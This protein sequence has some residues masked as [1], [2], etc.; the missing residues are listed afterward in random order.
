MR[1]RVLLLN[2]N[3]VWQEIVIRTIRSLDGNIEICTVC[4]GSDGYKAAIEN[5]IDVFIV[6]AVLC[7]RRDNLSG[8]SFISRIR[9]CDKY[10]FAP[11][12]VIC[13]SKSQV[14]DIFREHHCYD[15][16]EKPYNIE[17]LKRV[18]AGA[19]KYKT[20]EAQR[21]FVYIKQ[22]S[23]QVALK[24]KNIVHIQMKDRILRVYT[25]SGGMY[26]VYYKSCAELLEDV[27]CTFLFQCSRSSI[28][29]LEH[30]VDVDFGSR[31]IM[32]STGERVRIG[33]TY[34]ELLK[35]KLNSV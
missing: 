1:K 7:N 19:L 26:D 11:V 16:I 25:I 22:N 31:Y 24:C 29:N 27:G 10:L 17:Y 6:N 18:V 21:K 2:D 33:V 8:M 5:T 13:G 28:I 35:R 3:D 32:M 20:P 4:N 12:I 34:V 15:Y 23:V 9:E 30:V 14:R